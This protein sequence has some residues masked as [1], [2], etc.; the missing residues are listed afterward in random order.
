MKA[1]VPVAIVT[2]HKGNVFH[3][4]IREMELSKGAQDAI[5]RLVVTIDLLQKWAA[6]AN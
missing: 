4:E 3:R 5:V 1:K 2:D 6:K